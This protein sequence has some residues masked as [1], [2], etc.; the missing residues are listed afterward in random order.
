MIVCVFPGL[1]S[2]VFTLLTLKSWPILPLFTTLNLTFPTAGT[3]AF[4]SLNLKSVAVTVIVGIVA[5]FV[6]GTVALPVP[7]ATPR[8]Q[9]C[10]RE[11]GRFR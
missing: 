10:G 7:A 3:L 2:F 4:E 6:V 1:S 11:G 5:A 8:D 9:C